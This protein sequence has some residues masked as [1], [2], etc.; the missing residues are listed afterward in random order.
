MGG[1]TVIYG[2]TFS[3]GLLIDSVSGVRT[4]E[5]RKTENLSRDYSV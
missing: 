5:A 2:I 3:M 1:L 4:R